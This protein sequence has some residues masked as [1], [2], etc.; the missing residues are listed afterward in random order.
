VYFCKLYPTLGRPGRESRW[1]QRRVRGAGEVGWT[2]WV[3]PVDKG[4][5]LGP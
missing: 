1:D 2:C 4:G 3:A 5:E